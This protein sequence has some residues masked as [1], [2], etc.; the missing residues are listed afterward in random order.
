MFFPLIRRYVLM[1]VAIPLAAA[2]VRK[3]TDVVEERRGP[4]RSTRLLR[5]GADTVQGRF[6]RQKKRGRFVFGR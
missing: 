6:G 1:A 3:L 5:K 2:G 4:S